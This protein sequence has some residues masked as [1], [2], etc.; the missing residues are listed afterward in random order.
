MVSLKSRDWVNPGLPEKPVLVVGEARRQRIKAK[1]ASIA[2]ALERIFFF[3]GSSKWVN[4]FI[5]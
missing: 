4:L 3:M 2:I 1:S 5:G